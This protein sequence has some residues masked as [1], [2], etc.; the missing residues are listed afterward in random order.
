MRA[1]TGVAWPNFGKPQLPAT[2]AILRTLS[3]CYRILSE[4]HFAL[5]RRRGIDEG[6]FA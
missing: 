2:V 5:V 1:W 4:D 6:A 3:L